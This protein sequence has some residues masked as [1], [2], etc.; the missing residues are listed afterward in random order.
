MK[1]WLLLTLLAIVISAGAWAALRQRAAKPQPLNI[2]FTCDVRGRLVPCGCF[3]GQMGGL[4]RIATLVG[5][6]K[7]ADALKVD[8]G[9]AIEGPEDYQ[10]IEHRYILK[11]F[12]RLGYEAANLGHGEAQLSLQHLRELKAGA[13]V[14]LLSA[15]L[16][17]NATSQ[18]VFDTHRI[19]QRGDFR[20]ALIGAMSADGV[21][22]MLGEGLR[23]EPIDATLGRLL[24]TL[25][26]KADFIVL[27]AF[28]DEEEMRRLARD[29][30]ELDVILGGKVSQ[31]S[32]QLVRE[33]R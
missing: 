18:P 29:F 10:R 21:R 25:K 5:Q 20:I 4:T 30:Y 2:H 26:D 1:R 23:V 16:L 8:I 19:V 7:T 28:A 31:P 9:N 13:P 15:N 3:T 24:P 14:P 33:N 27:L 17:E 12:E 6:G 11:A 22:N 32:Q